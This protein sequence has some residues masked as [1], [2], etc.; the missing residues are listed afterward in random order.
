MN[1]GGVL[2]PQHYPARH[3]SV[4]SEREQRPKALRPPRHIHEGKEKTREQHGGQVNQDRS[5]HG[6][7]LAASRSRN[8]QPDHQMGNDEHYQEET[9][10]RHDAT[11]WKAE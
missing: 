9:E 8:G 11:K 7:K 3:L 1:K 10:R 4:V 2:P 5:L 6:L